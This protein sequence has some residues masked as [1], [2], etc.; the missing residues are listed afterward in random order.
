MAVSK[1]RRM[2]KYLVAAEAA[3]E[4]NDFYAAIT[5]YENALAIDSQPTILMALG[6]V[7][8]QR[9]KTRYKAHQAFEKALF[10]LSD[11]PHK[12]VP[13][14]GVH[15]SL[16][17]LA[18]IY[19]LATAD[20]IDEKYGDEHM[21]DLVHATVFSFKSAADRQFGQ[22]EDFV[23]D[24]MVT[25]A[26]FSAALNYYLAARTAAL[27]PVALEFKDVVRQNWQ[28]ASRSL[29]LMMQYD[30][31]QLSEKGKRLVQLWTRELFPPEEAEKILAEE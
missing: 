30:E 31:E 3:Q 13:Y 10:S 14:F 29:S 19:A 21:T 22:T 23:P 5:N 4:N 11:Q 9:K 15:L 6:Q 12:T 7:A 1:K 17:G 8:L 16:R 24:V 20:V 26:L 2:Q 25:P 27:Y 18:G 28:A